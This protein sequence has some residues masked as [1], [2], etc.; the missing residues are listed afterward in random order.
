MK[1]ILIALLTVLSF[2]AFSQT[3][4]TGSA[5]SC[6][7]NG[8]PNLSILPANVTDLHRCERVFDD[9]NNLWY[10][11]DGTTYVLENDGTAARPFLK[12]GATSATS[13][14]P[15]LSTDNVLHEG[16][17]NI[18]ANEATMPFVTTNT[19][20]V[21]GTTRLVD[22][23]GRMSYDT[24]RNNAAS[25][26]FYVDPLIGDDT[27]PVTEYI[28]NSAKRFKT[29]ERAIDVANMTS[30]KNVTFAV[31]GTSATAPLV[32]TSSKTFLHDFV[33]IFLA[34]ATQVVKFNPNVILSTT[35]GTKVL[36]NGGTIECTTPF[37]NIS[38]SSSLVINNNCTI[39]TLGTTAFIL[40]HNTT[41]SIL[42]QLTININ[43]VNSN[44]FNVLGKTDIRIDRKIIVNDNGF[45]NVAFA[46]PRSMS[47][48]SSYRSTTNIYFST[49]SP[50]ASLLPSNVS[51]NDCI[52]YNGA[53]VFRGISEFKP[54]FNGF[55]STFELKP[56]RDSI[57]LE[58][59]EASIPVRY[60]RINTYANDAAAIAANPPSLNITTNTAASFYGM[61]KGDVYKK[62]DG[63]LTVY[64]PANVP[65]T[66][67]TN[68][69]VNPYGYLIVAISGATQVI[70]ATAGTLDP[71]LHVSHIKVFLQ[72]FHQIRGLDYTATIVGN[73][74]SI[75]FPTPVL[76]GQRIAFETN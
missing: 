58:V 27:Y 26:G 59:N 29:L 20:Q 54:E 69:T 15:I 12:T 66:N 73:T 7:T 36:L 10:K 19:L 3:L 53:K 11:F 25:V 70:T 33:S 46:A 72:G 14:T 42:A 74:V 2:S 76:A 1:K 30:V 16:A 5:G 31:F 55:Y 22:K 67:P 38:E 40:N 68:Q 23:I 61:Y 60:G 44:L 9:L 28:N 62:P 51:Y 52:I 47:F 57:A 24:L 34:S 6:R 13:A 4:I 48:G 56:N 43:V 64:D 63:T 32:V 65:S 71:L 41:V 37:L 18:G 45:G 21:A 49:G 39:N 8:D 75:V 35:T 50:I 17:V